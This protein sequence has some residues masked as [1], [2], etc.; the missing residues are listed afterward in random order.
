[1]NEIVR[2]HPSWFI[3]EGDKLGALAR[4]TLYFILVQIVFLASGYVIHAGLGRMLGPELY[5]TFGVVISLVTMFNFILT[6]G[7]PQ[8]ASRYIALDKKMQAL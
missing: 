5:G 8:A 3:P 6:T 7:L 2:I 1:M 4:G